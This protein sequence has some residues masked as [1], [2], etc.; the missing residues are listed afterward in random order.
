[1][2]NTLPL[3]ENDGARDI[4]KR[5]CRSIGVS[6]RVL[7]SL[8]EAEFDQLGKKTKRGI[9]QCFDDILAEDEE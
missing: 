7:E 2:K 3:F 5:Q 6:I 1:M 4:T 9:R 8:V